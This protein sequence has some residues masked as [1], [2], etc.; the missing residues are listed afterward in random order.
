MSAGLSNEGNTVGRALLLLFF[1]CMAVA[2]TPSRQ[3]SRRNPKHTTAVVTR[4]K[5]AKAGRGRR[6]PPEGAG[7]QARAKTKAGCG[8]RRDPL[9]RRREAARGGAPRR[10]QERQARG[11][12]RWERVGR[13]C[14]AW[15]RKLARRGGG[16]LSLAARVARRTQPQTCEGCCCLLGR[17]PLRR[18]SAAV[19]VRAGEPSDCFLLVPRKNDVF[20]WTLA[21]WWRC[22]VLSSLP[23]PRISPC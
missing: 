11:A 8:P 17:H 12:Q 22:F 13:A 15:R 18:D 23:C 21:S 6:G 14:P 19:R 10:P 4:A 9:H 20:A 7:V 1:Y 5:S 16:V 3:Q 2:V